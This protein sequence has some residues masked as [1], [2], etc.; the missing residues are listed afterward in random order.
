MGLRCPTGLQVA[1]FCY[2]MFCVMVNLTDMLSDILISIR[3]YN[4]GHMTFFGI[5]MAIFAIA[6]ISYAVLFSILFKPSYGSQEKIERVQLCTFF[7]VLPFG[8]LVP[9]FVWFQSFHWSCLDKALRCMGLGD[10]DTPPPNNNNE[11]PLRQYIRK[12][13]FQHGGFMIEAMVE[14]VPQSILQMVFIVVFNEY[15]WL[16]VVSITISMVSVASKGLIMS[17]CIDRPTFIFNFLCCVSDVFGVFCI[18][19]WIFFTLPDAE[20]LYNIFYINLPIDDIYTVIWLYQAFVIAV[21]AA[22]M[23]SLGLACMCIDGYERNVRRARVNAIYD[24]PR[25]KHDAFLGVL[26]FI[27]GCILFFPGLIVLEAMK[28]VLFPVLVFDS[29]DSDHARYPAGYRALFEFLMW[30]KDFE[31]RVLLVNRYYARQWLKSQGCKEE[32]GWVPTRNIPDY[33]QQRFKVASAIVKVTDNNFSLLWAREVK[34][35]TFKGFI[36]A[37]KSNIDEVW[38]QQNG[39]DKIAI[40]TQLYFMLIFAPLLVLSHFYGILYPFFCFA[41]TPWEEIGLLQQMLSIVYFSLLGMMVLISW[42]VNEFR[43]CNMFYESFGYNVTPTEMNNIRKTYEQKRIIR[44]Q[45]NFGRL[46]VLVANARANSTSAITNHILP[47]LDSTISEFAG[48]SGGDGIIDSDTFLEADMFENLVK[49]TSEQSADKVPLLQDHT[50]TTEE[51]E[52]KEEKTGVGYVQ[53]LPQFPEKDP[54]GPYPPLGSS[55]KVEVEVVG[56]VEQKEG[57][58]D[59]NSNEQLPP[60]SSL[61]FTR[62]V[63][64]T[65]NELSQGLKRIRD[66]SQSLPQFALA[67]SDTF[68]AAQVMALKSPKSPK[69]QHQRAMSFSDK[70]LKVVADDAELPDE[71]PLLLK[72]KTANF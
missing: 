14:S 67:Q 41:S 39:S 8:Q 35:V 66:I 9:C 69:S 45:S 5:S 13:I 15:H 49:D 52:T 10:G 33:Y 58:E 22:I 3:W 42:R 25:F 59:S 36:K 38:R 29:I 4:Q 68:D 57:R 37:Y 21:A 47:L 7:A 61:L 65:L 12:K 50:N 54:L 24:P 23:C 53:T 19:S 18:A 60:P 70:H 28:L 62:S 64:D 48:F 17:Y 71:E 27:F 1:N 11:D 43:K 16:N 20:D 30:Q 44:V 2:D 51:T 26:V 63:S 40:V 31:C 55:L 46:S 72:A 6:Q 56:E 34:G 32:N